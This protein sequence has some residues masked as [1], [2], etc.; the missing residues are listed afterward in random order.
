[1]SLLAGLILTLAPGLFLMLVIITIVGLAVPCLRIVLKPLSV[2]GR[3]VVLSVV[4]VS[5]FGGTFSDTIYVAAIN[6]LAKWIAPLCLTVAAIYNCAAL[7]LA[8][9]RRG[10][11]WR[12]ISIPLM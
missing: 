10:H 1:M 3:L 6:S 9:Y 2:P 4:L 12:Q 5:G 8:A 11:H 7:P